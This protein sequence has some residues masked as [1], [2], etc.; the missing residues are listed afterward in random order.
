MSVIWEKTDD[1]AE[2]FR[3]IGIEV[4]DEPLP[5][6]APSGY[7]VVCWLLF[8]LTA[9]GMALYGLLL[10]GAWILQALGVNITGI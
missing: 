8:W 1:D 4:D 9:G 3:A 10:A 7:I 5:D 2:Y 6:L